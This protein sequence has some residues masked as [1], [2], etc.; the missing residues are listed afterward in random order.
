MSPLA[1][2]VSSSP[3][4]QQKTPVSPA[5]PLFRPR[6]PDYRHGGQEKVVDE[7]SMDDVGESRKRAI[8]SI[9]RGSE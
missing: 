5:L 9:G 6:H 8:D 1:T 4:H 2:M 3:V 7:G